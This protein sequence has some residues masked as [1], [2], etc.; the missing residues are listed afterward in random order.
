[1]ITAHSLHKSEDLVTVNRRKPA[2]PPSNRP[3]IEPVFGN[4]ARKKLPIPRPIDDYNHGMGGG[5]VA[6]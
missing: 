3:I 4:H 1:M 6:N 5:D 2:I